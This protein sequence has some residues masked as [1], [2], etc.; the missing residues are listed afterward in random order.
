MI[1]ID[2]FKIKRIAIKLES[3]LEIWETFL[4]AQENILSMLM[5]L[6]AQFF[7]HLLCI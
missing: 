6:R 4:E 7:F 1:N 2:T 5:F 3:E